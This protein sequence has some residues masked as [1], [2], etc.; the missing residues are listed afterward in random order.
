[1]GNWNGAPPWVYKQREA[2]MASSYQSQVSEL[3][4]RIKLLETENSGLKQQLADIKAKYEECKKL[5]E[6]SKARKPTRAPKK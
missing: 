1:M 3:N 4:S 2:N 5:S 6:D